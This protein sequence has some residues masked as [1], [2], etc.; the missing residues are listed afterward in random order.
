MY[1]IIKCIVQG[2]QAPVKNAGLHHPSCTVVMSKRKSASP[3]LNVLKAFCV[4]AEGA[5]NIGKPMAVGSV[6]S[7]HD[8][9]SPLHNALRFGGRGHGTV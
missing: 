6:V 7:L 4:F 2:K 5:A 1:C 3:V 9:S 8:D